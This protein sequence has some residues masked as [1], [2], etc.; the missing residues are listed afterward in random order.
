MSLKI[1][2]D[3]TFI[4]KVIDYF[5]DSTYENLYALARHKAAKSVYAN[6]S[7]FVFDPPHI[8]IFWEGILKDEL[9]KGEKYIKQLLLARDFFKENKS[10]F[11]QAF[12][13]LNEFIPPQT[14][15]QCKLHLISGYDIGIADKM[16]ACIN[17]GHSLFHEH[18]RELLYFSMHELHHVVYF[19]YQ[20]HISLDGMKTTKDIYELIRK[21]TH[22]EGLATYLTLAKRELEKG[23]TFKDYV[24][25]T[26]EKE[27]LKH[28]QEYFKIL[29][30]FKDLPVREATG[31]DFT[32]FDVMSGGPR[33]WYV[34]GAH[35]AQQ[36]DEILGREVLV[37]TI[38]DG[39]EPFFEHYDSI[40]EK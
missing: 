17:I 22:L 3:F 32:F 13:E 2:I 8:E 14:Q 39:F 31:E 34:A 38:V 37:Q 28:L 20:P 6:A 7:I 29:N 15:L 16:R 11:D 9:K 36:I 10:N 27:R 40:S 5:T 1:E 12:T 25:L 19:Q 33:Y 4:N 26:N 23:L 30:K 35:I 24:I 18:P 21:L